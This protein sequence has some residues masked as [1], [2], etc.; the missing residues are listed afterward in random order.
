MI[1]VYIYIY[2][3]VYVYVCVSVYTHHCKP[4]T[5]DLLRC[6]IQCA[7]IHGCMLNFHDRISG[8]LLPIDHAKC[9]PHQILWILG[10][11][12]HTDCSHPI[13]IKSMISHETPWYW[14]IFHCFDGSYIPLFSCYPGL[15]P[16][17]DP[18]QPLLQ[19]V[20]IPRPW[21]KKT[22]LTPVHSMD[23]EGHYTHEHLNRH[24][25]W[26]HQ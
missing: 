9:F 23:V 4:W 8:S 10:W 15:F 1:Y 14:V 21:C 11:R 18:H 12:H 7:L 25:R 16:H 3:N 13:C 24:C 2:I 19:H 5:R 22:I 26:S 20:I 6:S 17:K